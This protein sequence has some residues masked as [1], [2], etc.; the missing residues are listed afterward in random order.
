[1]KTEIVM[2]ETEWKETMKRRYKKAFRDTIIGS[3]EIIGKYAMLF[4]LFGGLPIWM[5]L[6]YLSKGCY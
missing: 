6:D 3:L 4:L 2:T 1:M 5:I